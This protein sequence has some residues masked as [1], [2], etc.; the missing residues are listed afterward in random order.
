[1]SL[2]KMIKKMVQILSTRSFSVD[3]VLPKVVF[4]YA[5]KSHQL[6][7]VINDRYVTQTVCIHCNNVILH[8]GQMNVKGKTEVI[9]RSYAV[10]TSRFYILYL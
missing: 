7:S 1:M 10:S 2:M 5:K 8:Y 6:V 4:L 3:Q 9:F